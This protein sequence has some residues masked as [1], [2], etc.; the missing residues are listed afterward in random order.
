[1]QDIVR[2]ESPHP[3]LVAAK[4]SNTV[5]IGFLKALLP[6]YMVAITKQQILMLF[7]ARFSKQQK[8][9]GQYVED[10]SAEYGMLCINPGASR[11]N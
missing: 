1:M 7:L 8:S 4:E 9:S 10:S 6:S 5:L 11:R 2:L 3:P